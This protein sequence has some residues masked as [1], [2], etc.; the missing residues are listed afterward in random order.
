MNRTLVIGATFSAAILGAGVYLLLQVSAAPAQPEIS[1]PANKPHTSAAPTTPSPTT[2]AS[3][4]TTRMPI[5]RPTPVTAGGPTV[6]EATYEEPDDKPAIDVLRLPDTD[7]RL[8][9]TAA[10]DEANRAYD[11]GDFDTAR[12][13]AN[14]LLTKNPGNVRLMRIVVSSGCMTGDTS[15]QIAATYRQLPAA[16]REQMK[17]RCERYNV[18]FSDP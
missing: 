11:R 9:A 17:V 15:E 12:A 10:F 7:P 5:A 6:P 16:D 3:G 13:M 8:T 2:I 1:L 4:D 14:K 18:R